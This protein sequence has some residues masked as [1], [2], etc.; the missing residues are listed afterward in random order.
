MHVITVTG[1][2]PGDYLHP[3][4]KVEIID[5]TT[6]KK[7][8]LYL[9]SNAMAAP[10]SGEV[11]LFLPATSIKTIQAD[12]AY[13]V[14]TLSFATTQREIAERRRQLATLSIGP[15]RQGASHP[16]SPKRRKRSLV[17][18]TKRTGR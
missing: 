5:E 18:T 8:N 6:G 2:E 10:E 11:S 9:R 17:T 16:N 1:H 3:D 15:G 7:Y 12:N 4:Q 13:C 14:V